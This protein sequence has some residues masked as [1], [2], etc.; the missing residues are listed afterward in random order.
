MEKLNFSK[1][2]YLD[3]VLEGWPSCRWPLSEF[4]ED[5]CP[6]EFIL[7]RCCSFCSDFELEPFLLPVRLSDFLLL[8]LCDDP[9]LELCDDW[10]AQSSTI[11]EKLAPGLWFLSRLWAAWIGS[12]TFPPFPG[13][14]TGWVDDPRPLSMLWSS[15]AIWLRLSFKK[16]SRVVSLDSAEVVELLPCYRNMYNSSFRNLDFNSQP[17]IVCL[18]QMFSWFFIKMHAP[19]FPI[20]TFLFRTTPKQ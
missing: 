14:R 18:M 6:S 9:L 13:L 1:T 12:E 17:F 2:N 7:S 10:F 11:S 16:L 20:T 4:P 3:N 15:L 19:S 5:D 8:E